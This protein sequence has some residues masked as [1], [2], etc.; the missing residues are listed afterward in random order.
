[1]K[2]KNNNNLNHIWGGLHSIDHDKYT[3]ERN[4]TEKKFSNINK[5]ISIDKEVINNETKKLNKE[6]DKK[7][8]EIMK[9]NQLIEQIETIRKQKN[10]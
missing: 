10:L 9:H 4:Q 6:I 7:N 2:T 3:M 5:N 1:L 8:N